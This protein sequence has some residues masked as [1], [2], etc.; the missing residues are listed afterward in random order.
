VSVETPARAKLRYSAGALRIGQSKIPMLLVDF[1]DA[2]NPKKR[3]L[4]RRALQDVTR[5]ILSLSRFGDLPY[6]LVERF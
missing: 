2:L 3:E 4:S 6:F 5:N 1:R